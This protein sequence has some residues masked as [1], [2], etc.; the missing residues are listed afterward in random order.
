LQLVLVE[1]KVIWKKPQFS[2]VSW[3]RGWALCLSVWFAEPR[4]QTGQFGM[5]S[6]E[7]GSEQYVEMAVNPL[8][9]L[10]RPE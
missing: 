1:E 3:N 2:V 4:H 5:P 6:G 10:C 8:T 7:F 9:C